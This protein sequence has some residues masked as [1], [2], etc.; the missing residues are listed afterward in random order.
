MMAFYEGSIIA[1]L[2]VIPFV[3]MVPDIGF[4][5]NFDPMLKFNLLITTNSRHF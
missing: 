5:W 2:S 4:E 1:D 3:N